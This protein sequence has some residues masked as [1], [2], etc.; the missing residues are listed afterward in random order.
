MK[1]ALKVTLA[2]KM[3]LEPRMLRNVWKR[4]LLTFLSFAGSPY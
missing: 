1:N 4:V 2:I 3:N